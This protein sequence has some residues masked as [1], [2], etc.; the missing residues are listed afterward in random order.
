VEDA[1][2]VAIA[3]GAGQRVSMPVRERPSAPAVS[4]DVTSIPRMS[5]HIPDGDGEAAGIRARPAADGFDEVAE[6]AVELVRRTGRVTNG[7][8]REVVPITADEARDIFKVLMERGD[9]VRRGTKRGTHYVM[10]EQ[11]APARA[12]DARFHADDAT[13]G[14]DFDAALVDVETTQPPTPP[15]GNGSVAPP[16]A[17]ADAAARRPQHSEDTALRRLLRRIR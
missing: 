12:A 6:I 7:S 11:A 3:S 2:D 15:E 8:L 9:L 16:H 14:L 13:G 10:P 5:I 1:F 4:P 17:P